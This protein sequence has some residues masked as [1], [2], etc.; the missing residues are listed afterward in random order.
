[1]TRYVPD[2]GDV[3]WIEF[4]PTVG[5]EQAGHRPAA[6]LT[7]RAYNDRSGLLFCVPLT[8]KAKGYPFEVPV[9]AG[10]QA[11]VALV[12]HA[13]SIDWESRGVRKKGQLSPEELSHIRSRLRTLTGEP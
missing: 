4:S 1:M 8:T 6:V 13:R 9:V 5:R 10:A 2:A 12:D 11:G 3:V 7:S